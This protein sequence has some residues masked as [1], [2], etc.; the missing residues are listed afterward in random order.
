VGK[1]AFKSKRCQTIPALGVP[2][3]L[4]NHLAPAN[5]RREGTQTTRAICEDNMS[6][7]DEAWRCGASTRHQDLSIRMVSGVITAT[8]PDW[9]TFESNTSVSIPA[10]MFSALLICNWSFLRACTLVVFLA[11]VRVRTSV[12]RPRKDRSMNEAS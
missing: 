2:L 9:Q 8:P 5:P 6:R 1:N 4:R 12:P 7:C 11:I 3:Y 10:I